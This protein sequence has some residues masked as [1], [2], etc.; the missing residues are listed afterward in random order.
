[1]IRLSNRLRVL[2]KTNLLTTQFNNYNKDISSFNKLNLARAL[3]SR[4]KNAIDKAL[5]SFN[6]LKI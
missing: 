3:L 5:N 2:R 6:N 4:N 1:M